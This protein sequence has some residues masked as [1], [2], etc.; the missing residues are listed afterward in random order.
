LRE[1]DAVGAAVEG[2][3]LAG[4]RRLIEVFA[5]APGRSIDTREEAAARHI[6]HVL[7]RLEGMPARLDFRIV[8][9]GFLNRFLECNV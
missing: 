6:H 8:E 9:H 7:A 3:V 4:K 2:G 1:A 5:P